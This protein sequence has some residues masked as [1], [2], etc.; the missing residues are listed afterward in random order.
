[1]PSVGY[2]TLQ[3]IPSVRGISD[4]IRRQ[5]IG[6]A[7][8][9]GSQAGQAAGG[10]LAEK[11]K[12]GA[13]A[14]GLAA[15]AL[16]VKGLVDAMDQSN[17]TSKL[18]AQ[19][20]S[21]NKVAAQQG[22]L[23]GKLYSSGV[24]DSFQ[25]AADA[26]KSVM[27]SGLAPPGTTTKQL[28]AI[29]TK[30]SDVATVFD[31]DLGG[32][33]NAVSQMMRTGLAKNS[34][35]AFDLITKGFQ[36]GAD[37]GGDLLDT[38]NEY[39]TSFRTL[40]LDGKDA[41]GLLSQGLKG[42][43]RDAD[44]VADALKEFSLVAGQ[45]GEATEKVFKSIGLNGKQITKDVA[46]GGE[47][48]RTALAQVL[49]KMRELPNSTAKASA[50]K[51]LFGGPG[52]DLGAALFTLN[53]NKASSTLGSFGGAA[54]KAGKT[55]RS[56]PS[57]EI[58][59]FTRTLKQGFIDF[60]GG[61]V[62]PVVSK[63]A[64][65]FNTE[66]LPPIRAVGSV[67]AA[68]LLP[69]LK[70]LFIAGMATV[71]WLREWGVWLAPIAV[72][73]GGIALALN[74]Q[75]IATGLVT[76]VFSVYRAAM[77][78]GTAVTSGFAAAQTLLNA[79][80]ALNPFVLVA[81]ALVALGVA[82]V[83]A[84]QKSETFRAIVQAAFGA[85]KTAVVAVVDWFKGPFL[86]FF[87]ETIPSIFRTV[88]DWVKVN[89]P[90]ILGALTGPIGLA[91]VWI[92]KNWGKIRTG[93]AAGWS[94]I[95]ST[96]LYPIRDFFTKTIPGWGNTLRDKLVGSFDSARAG[97]KKAWDKVKSIARGPVAFIVNTVYSKGI[98][99]TWNA[100][101][102]AFGAPTLDTMKFASGGVLPGYTPGR[103]VHLAALSGG[104]AVMRPEWTRA[105]GPGYVH[106]MNAAARSGGVGAIRR[107]VSGGM[108]AF[109]DGGIFDWVGKTASKGVDLAKSGVS[110]LKDGMKASAVAGMSK[111]VKPLIDAISGSASLYRD[112]VTGIP[113]KMI[114][115]I[116]SFSGQA[117]KKLGRLGL[118]GGRGYK[119]GLAWARTQAGKRY[120]W[121]GNGNPSWDCSGFL[122][123]IESVIR[124]QKPHRRWATG[125]FSGSSAPPGWVLGKKSPYMIGITNRGVGHTA[126]TLNGV[127]VESRGGD[128]VVVGGRARSYRSSLFTHRYGFAAKGYADGG[129]PARGELA[130][131]GERG[132][133]LIR[134]TGG[135]EVY[136]HADS[137]RMAAGL[138][139]RGFAKGT[140][141]ARRQ[142]PGD[143]SAFTKSLTGSASGISKAAK[144]LAK[145][146][147]SA[148]G[149]GKRLS[150]DA[151]K[152]SAKL[153]DM[154]TRRDTVGQRL[155]DAKQATTDQKKAADDFFGLSNLTSATSINDLIS[156]MRERQSTVKAFQNTIKS[157]SKK[158]L[159]QD[160]IQ[161]LVAQG[162]ES[163]LAGLV[164]GATK[165]Q[166]S[167]LNSLAK[168][169]ETL[170]TSYSRTMADAMY[171]AGKNAS[172]GFL[173][174][175]QSQDKEL[176]A[177]MNKLGSGLV[178]SIKKALKIKSPSR[179]TMPLGAYT[180]Q[181][182]AIGLDSTASQV[183]AAA[184]RVSEAA[185]P[186]VPPAPAN[187]SAAQGFGGR[188]PVLLV[189]EDGAQFPAY[190]DGRADDR[191]D[192]KFAT[193]RQ[194]A[195]AGRK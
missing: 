94:A 180:G 43:A 29:A 81:I 40:G 42:G 12:V 55:I 65:G 90:W 187:A 122:S 82:L 97:I 181:G 73:V 2:A 157:L 10:N 80:M 25:G 178:K 160:L 95:K 141:S 168:T 126:G 109:A 70:G 52:E 28:E 170:S 127:N 163:T 146:L 142:V 39:G 87:T 125:A 113:K 41:L 18:Q 147:K 47:S 20:G 92:I 105:V 136:N 9:A 185:V 114:N 158:G 153:Q 165:S 4:E 119:G 36:K 61:Q 53:L 11:L 86:H 143:L 74:A 13:A 154:A 77:I 101:A 140:T 145:D 132:P 93:L 3:V 172:R 135:E 45:G 35:E 85:V 144:E 78:V 17:V 139:A 44:Q 171:D 14:A 54:D 21:S 27:Q 191:V 112:M 83:V 192:K 99:P 59:V 130:W 128:G 138:S 120:Q 179:V 24:T 194:T 7:G 159:S 176:Q 19:L 31:Q 32:V 60:I 164:N 15:G 67:V 8:D 133:E 58:T 22:K 162:P 151:L 189:L 177:A 88:L 33:T 111:V 173:T 104:E 62:L 49:T 38:L 108:P 166:L 100:V 186:S 190:I 6:P 72:L 51:S 188:T 76:A 124:G 102:K 50:V 175:L 115:S 174:G 118:I 69:A 46:A 68:I 34:T 156:Q 152:A 66:L 183:A 137:M 16:L 193:V 23:A 57:H 106:T 121:G 110:W 84:Y 169:G 182:F 150:A 148:G 184:A 155:A 103:D 48:A 75:A 123:A 56:G 30:A 107:M 116:V 167:Q 37:K 131:V 96:V 134:F 64:H 79:V 26:I 89:W 149:A 63:L 98:V 71:G 161:Q 129:K 91:V 1:V 117:D 195:K 5:L